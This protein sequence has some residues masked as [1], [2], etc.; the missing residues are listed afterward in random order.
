MKK[1]VL[2][3]AGVSAL[4]AGAPFVAAQSPS[5]SAPPA[6][7]TS[8]QSAKSSSPMSQ[9]VTGCVTVG[10]D[11]KSYV[12]TETPSS[13][14]SPT[15]SSAAAPKTWTLISS[16]DVDLSKYANHKV[17]VTPTD[18][19]SAMDDTSSSAA[20]SS[21]ASAGPKLHVKSVKDISNTC[22]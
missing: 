7:P 16:G 17:E 9:P 20:R 2:L 13:T 1:Q 5:P 22:S 19:G 11:G 4:L 3:A 8:A 18:K 6:D 12:L 15:D 21:A 10:T 14:A